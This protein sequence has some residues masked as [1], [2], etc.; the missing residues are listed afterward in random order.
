MKIAAQA[1][2]TAALFGCVAGCAAQGTLSCPAGT[3]AATQSE[4]FFGR[5]R[6]NGEVIGASEWQGFADAEIA[7]RFPDGYSVVD[8]QG[9]WKDER[10]KTVQ[11]PS[12]VLIVIGKKADDGAKFSA[13]RDAYKR[14][15][16]QQSVLLVQSP[17]C[18]SF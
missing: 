8:A 7:T 18:A 11:E 5:S 6:A 12:K 4:L 9:A 1:F 13:I 17:A 14:Q 3:S 2:A 10:G 16:Q 15:F